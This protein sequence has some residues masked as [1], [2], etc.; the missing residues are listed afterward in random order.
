MHKILFGYKSV[1]T[2]LSIISMIPKEQE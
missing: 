2:Q 1:L